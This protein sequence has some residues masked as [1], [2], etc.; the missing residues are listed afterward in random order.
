MSQS[1][2]PNLPHNLNL[3]NIGESIASSYLEKKG[4]HVIDRN[5]RIRGGEIDL[6]ATFENTLVFIEVKTRIGETMGTPEDAIDKRK[7]SRIA[8]SA[9]YYKM[10]HPYLPDIMRIDAICI[11]LQENLSANY[12]NYYEN[13]T[14]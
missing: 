3:G 2:N 14:G 9:E 6:I 8:K 4:F 5:F 13:V 11:S 12:I 1:L 10:L 7:L